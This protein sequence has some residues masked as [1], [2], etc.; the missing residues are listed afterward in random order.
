MNSM[1]NSLWSAL[2]P[3]QNLISVTKAICLRSV[4]A[5]LIALVG[6]SFSAFGQTATLLGTVTDPS[7]AALPNVTV[8]VTSAES[9][10]VRKIQTNTAGQYVA[11]DLNIGHYRVKAEVTGFKVSERK[12]VVLQVGDRDRV[13]F[14][15]V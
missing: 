7:G 12:D 13:D 15:G 3:T 11:A 14:P 4:L 8:T 1:S 2:C 5:V 9:N 6:F 10:A